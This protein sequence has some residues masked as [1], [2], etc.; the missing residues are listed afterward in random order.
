MQHNTNNIMIIEN[1]A[2]EHNTWALIRIVVVTITEVVLDRS[3]D[4]SCNIM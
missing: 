1:W 2:L 3:R 4:K